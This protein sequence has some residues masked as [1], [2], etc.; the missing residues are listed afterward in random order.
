MKI[1]PGLVV[2]FAPDTDKHAS[3]DKRSSSAKCEI[4]S[5]SVCAVGICFCYLCVS[6]LTCAFLTGAAI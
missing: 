6:I 5:F 4:F 3:P 2:F 1:M